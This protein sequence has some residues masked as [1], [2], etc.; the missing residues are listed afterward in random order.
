M[1][2]QCNGFEWFGPVVHV[3]SWLTHRPL[4]DLVS[5][6]CVI[7]TAVPHMASHPLP[8]CLMPCDCW[9]SLLSR[10][11]LLLVLLTPASAPSWLCP[12]S[13]GASLFHHVAT[14]SGWL[15][16]LVSLLRHPCNFLSTPPKP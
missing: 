4:H 8:L 13:L 3:P 9:H 10:N 12:P 14:A 16:C 5:L 2:L 15:L 1:K 7:Y 11:I 6:L